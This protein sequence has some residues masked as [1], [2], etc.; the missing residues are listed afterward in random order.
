MV[1]CG[2]AIANLL[3]TLTVIE[4]EAHQE[5]QRGLGKHSHGIPKHFRGPLWGENLWIF[6]LKWCIW[7]YFIFLSNI[8]ARKCHRAWG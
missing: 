6:L 1:C 7:V 2:S 5:P 4:I 8:G 3:I